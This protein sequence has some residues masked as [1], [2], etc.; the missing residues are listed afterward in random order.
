MGR[1]SCFGVATDARNRGS[2]KIFPV[3]IQYFGWKEGGTKTKVIE[4]QA[5]ENEQSETIT[6]FVL[7]TLQK[8]SLSSKCVAYSGDNANVNFGGL[9]R[10]DG[11][12]VYSFLKNRFGTDIIGFSITLPC[13]Q[14]VQNLSRNYVTQLISVINNCYRTVKL[15]L[16]P[17]IGRI[18]KL[19]PALKSYFLSQPQPPNLIKK[20]FLDEFSEIYLWFLHS[21]MSVIDSKIK[22]IEK[23]RNC[24]LKVVNHLEST[25]HCP[26]ERH[27]HQL[28]TRWTVY[29]RRLFEIFMRMP[30]A[31]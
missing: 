17:A 31:V 12:N 3:L 7:N 11:Q 4:I 13:T 29:G 2:M 9:N 24:I 19:F 20:L 26:K 22:A 1:I 16:F 10:K 14:F 5:L 15:S 6:S 30:D 8:Y 28:Q 18:L 21:L 23:E 27:H 25:L